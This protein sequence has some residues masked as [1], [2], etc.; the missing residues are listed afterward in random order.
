MEK[1]RR[2]IKQSKIIKEM[3]IALL[4]SKML[5]RNCWITIMVRAITLT[6]SIKPSH[7]FT[8]YLAIP[9]NFGGSVEGVP[10]CPR[11]SKKKKKNF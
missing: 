10:H 9:F 4:E 5:L 3:P 8:T 1:I 6:P 7:F 11:F 2:M